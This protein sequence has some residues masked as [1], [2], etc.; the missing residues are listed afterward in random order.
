MLGPGTFTRTA[1]IP[2]LR[3]V[4]CL[5]RCAGKHR[6]VVRPTPHG[7]LLL[8]LEWDAPLGGACSDEFSLGTDGRLRIKTTIE[9]AGQRVEYTQVG[10][11]ASA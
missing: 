11:V 8:S 10:C 5:P 2:H 9:R 6:G 4:W 3:R 1:C 7:T